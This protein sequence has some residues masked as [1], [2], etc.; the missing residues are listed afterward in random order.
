LAPV[1][2]V[3]GA[4]ELV[5][6]CVMLA[7]GV[8]FLLLTG[9]YFGRHE[10][11][12]LGLGVVLLGGLS[13]MM[14]QQSSW[15]L[16][17]FP[18][19][20]LLWVVISLADNKAP[21]TISRTVFITIAGGLAILVRPVGVVLIP[22]LLLFAALN[23][24]KHGLKPIGPIVIWFAA[25]A[26]GALLVDLQR[27]SVLALDP[28]RM[29]K[30]LGQTHWGLD[31][32]RFYRLSVFESHLYPFP[33]DSLNDAFHA[34]TVAVMGLGLFVWARRA[35]RS[36]LFV[37]A[38]AYVGML[39]IVPAHQHRYLWPLFPLLV[40]GLL[41]G[42]R[43]V[44]QRFQS[45]DRVSPAR[46]AL[47][48]AALIAFG[49]VLRV[50]SIVEHRAAV[51]P[52]SVR[53]VFAKVRQMREREPIRVTFAKP[54]S[55]A[56][57]TGVPAMGPFIAPVDRSIAELHDKGITHLIIR[58]GAKVGLAN[59]PVVRPDAF[60]LEFRSDRYLIYRFLG[61]CTCDLPLNSGK[62]C[63]AARPS[64]RRS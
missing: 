36:F 59:L 45:A 62:S 19:A 22:A 16:T 52:A 13:S 39:L 40:Y 38:I 25:L 47:A 57:E 26:V 2:A 64:Q 55:L 50:P 24:R 58:T 27:V 61:A 56:W 60:R 11:R 1:L 41:E 14:L 51:E 44:A 54:R 17:D 63:C 34:V 33:A 5:L 42:I 30:W 10:D 23:Y 53:R 15:V 3:F 37:F 8:S 32:I 28:G 18:F 48:V 7:F 12:Q 43:L 9:A 46:M 35:H 49:Q 21:W 6:R 4:S 31:H 29:L 20:V